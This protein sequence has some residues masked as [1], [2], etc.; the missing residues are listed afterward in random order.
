MQRSD[1]CCKKGTFST[2]G[3][4]DRN[5]LPAGK[6]T[7]EPGDAL[8]EFGLSLAE[9]ARQGGVTSSAITNFGYIVPVCVPW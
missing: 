3:L 2:D 6:N 7:A 8:G 4:K 9:V 1:D 5:P